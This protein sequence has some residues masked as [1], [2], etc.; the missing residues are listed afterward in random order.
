MLNKW[1]RSVICFFHIPWP[2][3]ENCRGVSQGG[4]AGTAFVEFP[5]PLGSPASSHV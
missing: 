4:P 5:W 2:S 1:E 3:A